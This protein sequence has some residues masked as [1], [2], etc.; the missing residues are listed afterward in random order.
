MGYEKFVLA[1]GD[2]SALISV[3]NALTATGYTYIGYTKELSNVL[4][5]I[6]KY[7]PNLIIIDIKRNFRKLRETLN[8]IDEELLCGC[9]LILE[10]RDEEIINF[11]KESRILTYVVKPVFDENILQ[12]TEISVINYYRVLEY[13][14]K[15]KKLNETLE[16]RKIVEKAKWILVEEN[17]LSEAEAYETIQKKSRDSRMPMKN[18]A[19]A[20]IL[21]GGMRR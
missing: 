3:K 13:E 18:I 11:L 7:T 1:G 19:E 6:R 15:L 14:K 21:T 2:K 8:I 4:R 20:L 9:I 10:N 16:S 12:I 5:L 17:G